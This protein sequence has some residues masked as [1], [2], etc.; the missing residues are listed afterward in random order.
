[1]PQRVAYIGRSAPETALIEQGLE[2]LDYELD[3]NIVETP[4][5]II[6][7]IK[8]ADIILNG[9]VSMPKE[10]IDEIDTAQAIIVG[11]HGFNHIDHN[12][13]TE[14]NVMIV[15]CAGFCTEEVS[16]HAILMVM[17]CAKKLTILNDMVKRG[18]WGVET[19]NILMPMAP[20][21]GQTLGLVAFGNI[22]RAVSR[23][24]QA[25]G[26]D[27]IT[28]DP[29]C[30]PWITKEYRVRPV[31]TLEELAA[32]SDFVSVH[33]PLNDETRQLIGEPFFKA[34]KSAA[35]FVNTCRGPTVDE[36]A[37]IRALQNGEIAGA[38]LDVFEEEPT[39]PDNPLLK[40]DNVIVTP[41]SAGSSNNSRVRSPLR[42]G[43]ETARLLRGNW[44]MSIVNPEVRANITMR[45]MAEN[46]YGE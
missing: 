42:V 39:S 38:G 40:M 34:M 15:N 5:E 13:A 1:M 16:N 10:V 31:A 25:L 9:G 7:A 41:H 29:Y 4:G 32:D 28:Y 46:V 35:Y 37:L 23:K 6:E 33:M 3:I 18:K 44:P 2:G 45:P 20:I 14:K 17:A 22:A 26:M 11:S 19:R 24:A 21:D 43:Q 8:G 36:A 12:A 30:P 27:V